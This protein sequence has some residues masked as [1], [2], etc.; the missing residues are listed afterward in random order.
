M[1]R[2]LMRLTVLTC[3][4]VFVLLAV[5]LIGSSPKN[6]VAMIR[7]VDSA[8]RPVAGVVV[9][10]EGLRTKSGPYESGWYGWM[11]GSN[12]VTN[13]PVR[14][15]SD[16]Y[17]EVEYPKYVFEQIE[18]GTICFSV[19]HPDF[20][21][22]RLERVVA[23]SPPA[24]APLRVWLDDLWRRIRRKSLIAH[25]KPVMLQ[26]GA[27]LRLSLQSADAI[28]GDGRLFAQV[29]DIAPEN[30]Y[31]WT[32]PEPGVIET[33]RLGSGDHMVRA[34]Q[35]D[36]EGTAWFS[37]VISIK[38]VVGQTNDVKVSFNRGV[39]IRGQVDDTVPRPVT[40]GRVVANVW[41][42][43]FEPK[44]GPPRWHSWATVRAD[45]GFEIGSMPEGNLE[46]VAL[47]NGFVSTNCP[48]QF[49]LRYPQKHVIGTNDLAI[50]IGMEP[51]AYLEVRVNDDK[52]HPLK[53]VRVMT[54]PNIRYGEWYATILM[55]DCY[56][57]SDSYLTERSAKLD[58]RKPVL[59]FEAVSDSNGLA[60]LSNLPDDV[61][62]L[63]IEHPQFTLPA[64]GT[65]ASGKK[66]SIKFTLNADQTNRVFL[67]LEPR[68]KSLIRHY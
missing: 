35:F 26:A 49:R 12:P 66:R 13:L 24:G 4:I 34:I 31:F 63:S 2:V 48:G 61:A 32:R 68:D 8:G 18:T 45:G 16:G 3:V 6:P 19:N 64:I 67:R 14:T 54:N 25:S 51:T 57:S 28:L 56:K 40:N 15:G 42:H 58:W 46:I 55:S 39:T 22:E 20:V 60:V 65:T 30:E 50:T 47:C 62:E 33:R 44:D 53:D 27:I 52:G 41:P 38:A 17:A 10:P 5:W 11:T 1:K 7:V 23:T 21:P 37:K 36:T 59:D 29:S 43:G 9:Q